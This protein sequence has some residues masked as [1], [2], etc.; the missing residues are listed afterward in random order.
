MENTVFGKGFEHYTP[1]EQ[2][3]IR[4]GREVASEGMVLLEN[5]GTLPLAYGAKVALFGV[6]QIGFL[7]GGSGSG[8]TFADYVVKLPEAMENAGFLVDKTLL[9][10]YERYCAAEQKK[11][12]QEAPHMRRGTIPELVLPEAE[13]A[14]AA[15][16]NDVAVL[17]I[18][19][20]AGEGRDRKLEP[21]DY[22]L[23]GEEH[24]LLL[25]VKKHFQ[26]VVVLLN[27]CGYVDME[28]V[29]TY[30][31]SAVLMVWIPGQEGASAAADI[32][33]GRVNPSGRLADTIAK[34]WKDIPSSENF[35]AW[36]DGF[37]LY[38]GDESQ[39]PYWGGV[40]NHE[41]VPV[42]E[43]V[44]R[45]KGNRRYTEYQEGLYVGYRYFT[46]FGVPVRYHFGYGLSYTSFSRQTTGFQKAPDGVSFQVTVTNTGKVPG[47]EVVQIYLHGAEQPLERPDRELVAFQ[48]TKLLEP[49]ASQ[50]L[51]FTI[52]NRY[53]AVYSEE[54]AAWM[55]QEGE[56]TLYL[57]GD[58]MHNE[59]FAS[60]Q[61]EETVL[62]Q[63]TNQ[64]TPVHH[65]RV[66]R[67]LSKRNPEDTKPIAPPIA[68]NSAEKHS[69]MKADTYTW[70]NVS[71]A[72]GS[73]KLQDV[74]EGKVSMEEFLHQA[75]DFE[76][77]VLLVGANVTGFSA[78]ETQ[79]KETEQMVPMEQ[80]KRESQLGPLSECIPGMGGYT[81]T[82]E[83]L[84][85]PTITMCDGPAG[86]GA[87]KPHKLAFPTAT[88]TA[89]T[90]N[91]ELAE[92]LGDALGAEAEERKVDVWLAPAFN[93]HRNPLA[94][95]N[96]EYYSED[97]LVSGKIAAAVVRGA[98][99]N[100]KVSTCIK[101]FAANNQETS[102]WDKD[103]SVMTERVLREIYLRGFEIAVKEGHPH[104]LMTSYNP[105]NGK[106]T[107][108]HEELLQNILR[109]EW[110]FE[111]FVVTDWEGDTGLAVECLQAGNDLL[112]PGFPGMV[113][114]LYKKVQS[115]ALSRQVLEDCAARL[116]KVVMNSAA[117]ERYIQK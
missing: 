12:E 57:G 96:Y 87:G 43:T 91:T 99:E 71:S 54:K 56:N 76:L 9:S 40:G 30:R 1:Q 29:D 68:A 75:E 51:N 84:G 113:N 79:D 94:G 88:I 26:K 50:I 90:F 78:V 77:V 83:R 52:P 114:W 61:T 89:C 67:Q 48:K 110:G 63:V 49:N 10:R 17:S 108:T 60:F 103:D 107:A 14:K 20:L 58:S 36:A 55:L 80:M 22:Y 27:V 81:A 37:E 111:G 28:W 21:G 5:D 117:M 70:P 104:C 15:E 38:T 46:T 13:I 11:V 109:K 59:A 6:G 65:T 95:R 92:Q 18:A 102:R 32:L 116:L 45:P 112:M 86:I 3:R 97:P 64:V 31:P 47:K 115:G 74:K 53:L 106:Q 7:H 8:S 82:V 73:W 39:I 100:H 19:R 69:S 35:G 44:V 2:A 66:L 34:N 4:L 33:A 41:M 42:G 85:I 98:E 101:H 25:G 24:A 72:E 62:E 16:A 105:L 23:S 93:I